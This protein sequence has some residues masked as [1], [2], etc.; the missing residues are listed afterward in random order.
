LICD[1]HFPL[2]A[3]DRL[4]EDLRIEPED[5]VDYLLP[6]VAGRIE[7]RLLPLRGA[8]RLILTSRLTRLECRVKPFRSADAGLPK[9]KIRPRARREGSVPGSALWRDWR[10]YRDR[11]EREGIVVPSRCEQVVQYHGGEARHSAES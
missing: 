1:E 4:W 10:K 3:T 6:E 11:S 9:Q 2:R 7:A 5:W 8:G